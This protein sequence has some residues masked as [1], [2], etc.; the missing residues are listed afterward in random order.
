MKT[1]RHLQQLS[2]LLPIIALAAGCVGKDKVRADSL[3]ALTNEQL[4]LTTTL[5]AQKDSLNKVIFEA[6]N[7]ITQIDRQIRTVKGLPKSKRNGRPLE[8]PIA[9]QL[10]R[11]KEML[12]RVSALVARAKTTAAQLAESRRRERELRGENEQLKGENAKLQQE[13][14]QDQR[15]IAE[16][17]QTIERQ[18]ATIAELQARADSLTEA[19]RTADAA[20]Y[21]A[22][23]IIGT[24]RDLLEKGVVEREGGTHL[25]LVRFGRTLQ[26]SRTLKPE[27]FTAI[28]Q[29]EVREISVPD[30]TRRYRIV[31]RQSLDNAET[32]ERF[33]EWFTGNLKI[34]SA[35]RFW[36]A[37][38][39]L[40]LV[41]R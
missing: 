35:E 23:Y 25:L 5:S 36:A 38:P 17:G 27:L 29:R 32:K 8:S 14:D 39:Y 41:Q 10:Q 21:R 30:T 24:E 18:T 12:A 37:S 3:Q 11:R 28:D 19:M 13:L 6:D 1:R 20:R 4:K 16:L 31:S 26:P 2:T 15:T 22:Y 9:E 33:G 7:F 40:I 34:T